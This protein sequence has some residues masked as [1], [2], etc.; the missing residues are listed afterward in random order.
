MITDTT[1]FKEKYQGLKETLNSLLEE[2]QKKTEEIIVDDV[3]ITEEL[4][5]KLQK[6]Q[7]QFQAQEQQINY[8]E[9]RVQELTNLI[10]QQKEKIVNSYLCFSSEKELLKELIKAYLELIRAKKQKLPS[11]KLKKQN[12]RIEDEL[13]EK[14][15]EEFVEK[16]QPILTDCEDLVT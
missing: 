6:Q 10:K 7:T 16:I 4:I 5:E 1:N 14:L 13:I 12:Q 3:I 8:L 9:L 11:L 15:G 2:K